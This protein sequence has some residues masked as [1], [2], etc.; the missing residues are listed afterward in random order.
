MDSRFP[1]SIVRRIP[2]GMKRPTKVTT[3]VFVP[4]T[5]YNEMVDIVDWLMQNAIT[6]VGEG[7]EAPTGVYGRSVSA[8][9]LSFWAKITGSAADG[10][11]RWKYAW[12]EV[13][14]PANGYGTW[15]ATGR[16]GTTT[17]NPARNTVENM[18]AATGTQGN[19]VD[20]ANFSGTFAMQPAPANVIVRMYVTRGKMWF[21]YPN[22]VDGACE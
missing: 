13:E 8:S 6:N 12:A 11:N 20:V 16:T 17:T 4:A 9:G 3:T 1:G 7:L 22:A 14:P 15:I 5:Q 19:G 10:T 18:N 2:T 21:E